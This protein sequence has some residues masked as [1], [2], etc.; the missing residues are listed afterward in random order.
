MFIKNGAQV[1][2]CVESCVVL[3]IHCPTSPFFCPIVLGIVI[4]CNAKG[5]PE[6]QGGEQT[7]PRLPSRGGGGMEGRGG[8]ASASL[9][10]CVL[11]LALYTL[12]TLI[13]MANT[14]AL[15]HPGQS[16]ALAAGLAVALLASRSM[17]RDCIVILSGL[18]PPLPHGHTTLLEPPMDYLYHSTAS[19]APCVSLLLVS[20]IAQSASN[21]IKVIIVPPDLLPIVPSAAAW[22]KKKSKKATAPAAPAAAS[23]NASTAMPMASTA[24]ATK[25]G[26]TTGKKKAAK[27]IDL[28]LTLMWAKT[29][30]GASHC[31]VG[32]STTP[33]PS[34]VML[35]T[36]P[37]LVASGTRKGHPA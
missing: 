35:P 6:E 36:S 12:A 1:A 30:N 32:L 29:T 22:T 37:C 20:H 17:P 23:N 24:P 16:M 3:N 28:C 34:M 27:P 7:K 18:S 31:V 9:P 11:D 8:G 15:C 21:V 19:P 33:Q 13:R 2:F 5:Q 25:K 4:V 10:R 26:R 14:W